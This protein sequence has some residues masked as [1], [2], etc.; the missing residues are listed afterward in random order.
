[1]SAKHNITIPDGKKVMPDLY[2]DVSL[3][4]GIILK[5]VLYVPA[6]EFNQIYV[7]KLCTGICSSVILLMVSAY[8]RTFQ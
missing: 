8:L 6:F 4:D 5:N 3:M 1:M 7:H 2:G